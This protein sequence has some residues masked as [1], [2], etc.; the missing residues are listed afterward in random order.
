MTDEPEI[1]DPWSRHGWLLAAVWLVFLG[2]PATGVVQ[3]TGGEPLLRAVMLGLI[4]VFGVIYVLAFMC[5]Q[6]ALY[7]GWTRVRY[8]QVLGGFAILVAIMVTLSPLIGPQTLGM[9]AFLAALAAFAFPGRWSIAGVAAVTIGSALLLVTS[10]DFGDLWPLLLLPALIGGFGLLIRTLTLSDERRQTLQR[11]LAV[12]AERDRVARDVHDVL[13][14]S[15]TVISLKADLAER[16]IDIDPD[17]AKGEAQ[18][19]QRLTRQSLA[20]IRSTVAGLRMARLSDERD[21]AAAALRDAGIQAQLPEDGDVVDPGLRITIAWALREAV[22]NVIRHSGATHV[23]VRWGATWLEVVDDGRGL[24]GHREGSGLTG[25]R[26]R[27]RQSGGRIEIAEG[28]HGQHGPGT[29]LKVDL[30]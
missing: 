18:D 19:I 23:D 20:E 24:R 29:T 27:V 12:A 21:S 15:L 26:E 17:R 11:T 13:G 25:L 4:A 14:H 16:L 2:F 6:S 1:P 8:T 28:R 10:S 30:S 9:S 7:C 22:T 3:L 5:G